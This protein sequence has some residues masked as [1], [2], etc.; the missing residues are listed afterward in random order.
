MANTAVL[1]FLTWSAIL[2]LI[3]ILSVFWIGCISVECAEVR[4][5]TKIP[6]PDCAADRAKDDQEAMNEFFKWKFALIR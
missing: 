6:A 4:R 1:S 2:T 5:S 3:W